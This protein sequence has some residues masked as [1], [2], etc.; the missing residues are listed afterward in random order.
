MKRIIIRESKLHILKESQE[1]KSIQQAKRLVMDKMDWDEER[2]EKYVRVDVRGQFP[3]LRSK[4]GGKFIYGITRMLVN[5]QINNAGDIS[6]MNATLKLIASPAHIN[7]YDR[8]FNGLS[9]KELIERFSGAVKQGIEQDKENLSN[10]Q[11]TQNSNYDIVRIDTFEQAEQ[12]GQ[13]TSWCITHHSNMFGQYGCGGINQVYFLLKKGFESVEK[14]TGGNTPLDEY[15]LSMISVIVDEYGALAF[16]TCRWNHDNGGDDSIMDTNQVSQLIGRNFYEVFKP[17]TMF[18]DLQKQAVEVMLASNYDF[19]DV[20]GKISVRPTK[21][22][23]QRFCIINVNNYKKVNVFDD[24]KKQFISDKWYESMIAY[25]PYNFNG[26]TYVAYRLEEN[27]RNAIMNDEGQIVC[28]WYYDMLRMNDG[29]CV[30]VDD[31]DWFHYIRIDGKKLNSVDFDDACAFEHGLGFATTEDDS[32]VVDINGYCKQIEGDGVAAFTSFF[33]TRVADEYYNVYSK[34]LSIDKPVMSDIM[35]I[36]RTSDPDRAIISISDNGDRYFNIIG[37]GG[38]P[39]S[40]TWFNY[41][42]STAFGEQS[43]YIGCAIATINDKGTCLIDRDGN[44]RGGFFERIKMARNKSNYVIVQKLDNSLYNIMDKNFRLV[45][46]K[47]Y[48][49]IHDS[50]VNTFQCW[51]EEGRLKQYNLP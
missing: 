50:S 49:M 23:Y 45:L 43:S 18:A 7:E 35:T 17:N 6:R 3:A 15:G 39:L 51:D 29:V 28:D 10:Q 4:E 11:Y 37:N 16:C 46:P 14:V 8:D 38:E 27:Y 34:D 31:E 41:I 20:G 42:G 33:V 21:T 26:K 13:Y 47:D 9:P 32:F 25:E 19:Y 30:A 48:N 22:N 5:R 40:D 12:Y 2:A 44:I 1:S 36:D 24:R